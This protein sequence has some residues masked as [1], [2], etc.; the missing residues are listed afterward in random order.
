MH[1]KNAQMNPIISD[2]FKILFLLFCFSS[3][4]SFALELIVS[5]LMLP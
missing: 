5:F 4:F 1:V 3:Q 2:Q